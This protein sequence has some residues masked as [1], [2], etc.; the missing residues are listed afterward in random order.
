MILHFLDN[1][2][3]DGSKVSL[4][5][6]SPFTPQQYSWYSFVLRGRVEPRDIERLEGLGQL[7]NS[8][9]ST[10]IEPATIRLV[11]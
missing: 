9:T 4:T 10:G 3:I 2:L 8:V 11:A 7:R 6:Q 5:C 1:R